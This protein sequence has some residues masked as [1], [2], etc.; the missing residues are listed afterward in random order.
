MRIEKTLKI[1]FVILVSIGSFISCR[2]KEN[3]N[4]KKEF[5]ITHKLH[6]RKIPIDEVINPIDIIY[7]KDYFVIQNEY[8][9]GEDCFFVYDKTM[10]FC[11]SF[12]RLGRG[13]EEFIAPRLVYT[14]KAINQISIFDS[15]TDKIT[16]YELNLDESRLV[17]EIE[18]KKANLPTQYIS[19]VNDTVVIYLIE[20]IDGPCLYSYN[21]QTGEIV[22]ILEFNTAFKD[23]M[24][25]NYNPAIDVFKV[26]TNGTLVTIAFNF[27]DELRSGK[28]SS[29]G[30]F[31]FNQTILSEKC[32]LKSIKDIKENILYY[33]FPYITQRRIYAPYYGLPFQLMQP[34][35][36]NLKSRSFMNEIEVYNLYNEPV[37]LLSIDSEIL[38]VIVDEENEKLYTWDF[39]KDFDYILEY[40]ISCLN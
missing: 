21:I 40:D 33:I 34:F 2:N 24:A 13:P 6:G 18:I 22:D 35:P 29:E 17:T 8:I 37:A 15:A 5:P 39:L 23:L 36:F 12:G 27:I 25:S 28:I 9:V 38:R 20:E 3:S 31:D 16:K 26:S 7:T 32:D 4:I 1:L 14:P 19:Y 30:K 10:K 11:Y